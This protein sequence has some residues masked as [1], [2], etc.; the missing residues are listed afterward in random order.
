MTSA[1]QCL[2]KIEN[3]TSKILHSVR[4][5]QHSLC[6]VLQELHLEHCSTDVEDTACLSVVP[7]VRKNK[8]SLY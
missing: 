1:L 2:M 3:L 5:L 8:R 4:G 7:L 6:S